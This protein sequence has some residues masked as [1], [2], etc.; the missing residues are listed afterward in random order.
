M[1]LEIDLGLDYDLEKTAYRTGYFLEKALPQYM[2]GAGL[3]ITSLSS[4][5]ISDLPSSHSALNGQ[6][7]KIQKA[8]EKVEINQRKAVI[9]YNTIQLCSDSQSKPYK[10]ILTKRYIDKEA[11][12]KIAQIV[13]YSLKQYYLKRKLALCEFAEFFEAEKV[14]GGCLD[15]PVLTIQKKT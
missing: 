1:N 8:L 14:K 10:K 6:E 4:P 3:T 2:R 11:D 7:R 12:W 13:Q 5:T 9:I 15:M